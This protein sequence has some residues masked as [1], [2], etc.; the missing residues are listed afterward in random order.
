MGAFLMLIDAILLFFF[1]LMGTAPI[2]DAQLVL[3]LSLFPEWM[4]EYKNWYV[5]GFNDY[6][7]V[8]KPHFFVGL[9]LVELVFQWP[10]A[11][12]NLYGMLAGK[13]W[14]NTTCLD[15]AYGASMFTTMVTALTELIGSGKASDKLLLLNYPFLG[16]SLLAMLRGLLRPSTTTTSSKGHKEKRI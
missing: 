6:C 1:L 3:P 16:F 10:L 12:A 5:G 7:Y 14:Y 4:V 11:L 13:S 9:I 2:V 8:E 15:L